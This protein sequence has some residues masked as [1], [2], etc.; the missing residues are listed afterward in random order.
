MVPP[1]FRA[2]NAIHLQ[3]PVPD[4]SIPMRSSCRQNSGTSCLCLPIL[5]HILSHGINLF[6]FR[7]TEKADREIRWHDVFFISCLFLPMQDS[8]KSGHNFLRLLVRQYFRVKMERP[9]CP[10]LV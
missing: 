2:D 10:Y 6:H 5:S 9:Y 8:S 7:I 1:C 4:Y 3:S